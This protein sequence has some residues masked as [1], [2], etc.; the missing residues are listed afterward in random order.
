MTAETHTW[1]CLKA[2]KCSFKQAWATNVLCHADL[3]P[4]SLSA[5]PPWNNRHTVILVYFQCNAILWFYLVPC[6]LTS[7]ITLVCWR[8]NTKSRSAK[9][10]NH[11]DYTH[12]QK[13]TLTNVPTPPFAGAVYKLD[14]PLLMTVG[15]CGE[16]FRSWKGTM[17]AVCTVFILLLLFLLVQLPLKWTTPRAFI[18]YLMYKKK[19]DRKNWES[20]FSLPVFSE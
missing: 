17:K 14:C 7:A 18:Q 2:L 12:T 15:I 13:H 10:Q 20:F 11:S 4:W 19:R 9:Q 16:V 6:D 3:C 1:E 8:G 5:V